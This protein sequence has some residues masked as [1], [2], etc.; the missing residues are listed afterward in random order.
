MCDKSPR[1]GKGANLP[2]LWGTGYTRTKSVSLANAFPTRSQ[3]VFLTL[4]SVGQRNQRGEV[5]KIRCPT[6]P[7]LYWEALGIRCPNRFY[8]HDEISRWPTKSFLGWCRRCWRECV[9]LA[10]WILRILV[11]F[12][13]SECVWKGGIEEIKGNTNT[14]IPPFKTFAL[15]MQSM[16]IIHKM[17]ERHFTRKICMLL[18]SLRPHWG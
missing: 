15:K 9:R 18:S 1:G 3:R 7:T 17:C 13:S 16:G 4:D 10:L 12:T 8:W 2:F 11:Y 6:P 5:S 14:G